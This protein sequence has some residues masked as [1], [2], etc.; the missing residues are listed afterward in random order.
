M[1]EVAISVEPGSGYE[2]LY[3]EH[4]DR[5]WRSVFLYSG[6]RDVASDAVVEAFAQAIARG[7]E[8]HSPLAWVTRAAFRIAAGDLQERRRTIQPIHPVPEPAYDLREL[9]VPLAPE[10]ARLSPKQ[11]AAVILHDVEG[12][13]LQEV[14]ELIGSTTSAVGVHLHRA[15][16]RLRAMLEESEDA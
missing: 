12:F 1:R 5:L 7:D 16:R 6:D 10:L 15:H 13:R 4:G 14:A 3:R 9:E 11:R 2:A 8:I